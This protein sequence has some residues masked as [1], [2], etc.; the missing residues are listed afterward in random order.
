MLSAFSR[1]PIMSDPF[2]AAGARCFRL[3]PRIYQR[4]E[5]CVI[6]EFSH[7]EDARNMPCLCS[8]AKLMLKAKHTHTHS[9]IITRT[10]RQLCD[11]L[12]R[13][14]TG[15]RRNRIFF[16]FFNVMDS[17]AEAGNKKRHGS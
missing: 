4:G 11:V 15:G 13:G 16:F 17:E 7:E 9:E 1:A 12:R 10:Q 5:H 6:C 2:A 8:S 14:D 3:P